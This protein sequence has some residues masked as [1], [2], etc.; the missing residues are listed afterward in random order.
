MFRRRR[1]DSATGRDIR[2]GELLYA[3]LFEHAASSIGALAAFDVHMLD[4][5]LSVSLRTLLN[6]KYGFTTA[7]YIL[8]RSPSWT[9]FAF[10][11]I[12]IPSETQT[13]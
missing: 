8:K 6:S 12:L 11:H 9:V 4:V 10:C 5:T 13:L 7:N 1:I 2:M 3:A